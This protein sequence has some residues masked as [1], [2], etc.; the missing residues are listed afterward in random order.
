MQRE[1]Q[2]HLLEHALENAQA[3]NIISPL[4]ET[5]PYS[6]KVYSRSRLMTIRNR[7]YLLGY[8]TRDSGQASLGAELERGIR[9]FQQE[10]SFTVNGFVVDGWTGE[11]SWQALQELVSFESPANLGRWF[12]HDTASPALIRTGCCKRLPDQ[13]FRRA[14]SRKSS[15]NRLLQ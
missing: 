11:Q 7:L 3:D 4:L 1:R 8:I 9:A 14:M 12:L 2:Y 5:R 6:T 13:R 10:A 15:S